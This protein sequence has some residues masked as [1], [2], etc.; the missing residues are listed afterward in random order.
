M[1]TIKVYPKPEGRDE[2]LDALDQENS[3]LGTDKDKDGNFY[4]TVDFDKSPLMQKVMAEKQR[5]L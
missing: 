4:I 3:V 5:D 2:V 1:R